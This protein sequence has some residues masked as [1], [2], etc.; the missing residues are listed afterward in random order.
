MRLRQ[1]IV[2]QSIFFTAAAIVAL[3]TA[4]LLLFTGSRG[5]A[6]FGYMNPAE[7]FLSGS[8]NQN[9]ENFG[10]LPLL[11]GSLLTVGLALLI[12]GPLALGVSI[13]MVEIAPEPVRRVMR[14]VVELFAALPSVIYGLLGLTLVVPWVRESFGGGLGKGILAASI[15]LVFMTQPTIVSIAEDALR[16]LPESLREGALAVGATRWQMIWRVLLPAARPGLITAVVLGTGR[17][18]GE[19]IAVQMV[20]GNITSRM[21]KSLLTGATTMPAAIVTQLPEA[22]SPEH[23]AALIM[24]AFLLLVITFSL[25]AAVRAAGSRGKARPTTRRRPS[26]AAQTAAVKG[27]D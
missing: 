15:V 2:A 9:D 16:A 12:S 4:A 19:T 23:R 27:G 24:V 21:P 25:I 17:A 1:G 11:A 14:T 13:F 10:V 8:W 22:T 5:L 18:V 7:F 26:P 20:I 6:V 3:S